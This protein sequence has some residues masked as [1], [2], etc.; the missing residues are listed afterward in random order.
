MKLKILMD[1][2]TEIDVYYLGEPA[3]SY[4]LE[5]E[6]K[7]FLFD[8]GYS[9]AFLK[10]AKDMGIDVTVAEAI[11]LSH[12]HNDHTGGLRPLLEQT[13][14]NKPLFIAHPD[15]LLPHDW[16]GMDIGSP[17]S[18]AE[19]AESFEL[20]LTKEP[21]W[22]TE[23][24]L[25]LGEIPR[26]MDFEPAYAIGTVERGGEKEADYMADDTALAYVGE[27]GLS[28]ITGC[29][30]AGICNII[31]YAKKLT[32]VEKVQSVLGGFHL[33]ELDER[34]E[35]TI[36]FLKQEGIPELYPCHC[37]SFAV[38]AALHGECPVGEV[39][40]GTELEWK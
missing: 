25:W 7:A 4:W 24:F 11:L 39:A 3:V 6:G 40:V 36:A 21:V 10:N 8:A 5:T 9:D 17:V 23:K 26:V 16:N 32:G 13:F 22:L 1:N 35:A 38:R 20:K 12:S 19:L 29:S 2:H 31:A 33:F 34:A 14:G 30:H 28:I 37:T 27:D 15:A 18:E